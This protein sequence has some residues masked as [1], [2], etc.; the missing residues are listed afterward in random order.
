MLL[1]QVLVSQGQS[2]AD[3]PMSRA[4]DCDPA[5]FSQALQT[6]SDIHSIPKEV[7]SPAPHV[8]DMDPN[9]ELEPPLLWHSCASLTQLFL[10]CDCA[11]DGIHSARELS[12]HAIPSGVGNPSAVG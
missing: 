2:L 11:L 12:Q 8:T 6:C 4:R 1:T 7:S 5:R 10:D 3:I 9:S